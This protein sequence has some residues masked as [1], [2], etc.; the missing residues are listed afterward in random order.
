MII[1]FGTKSKTIKENNGFFVCPQCQNLKQYGKE[2]A[3]L[4][5]VRKKFLLDKF[6]KVAKVELESNGF[7]K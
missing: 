4:Q 7:S 5:A 1:I 2:S 3:S 6:G